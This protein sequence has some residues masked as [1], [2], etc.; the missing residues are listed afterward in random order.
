MVAELMVL[1][2]IGIVLV[3]LSGCIQPHR[4]CDILNRCKAQDEMMRQKIKRDK[5]LE[6]TDG[7]VI[8]PPKTQGDNC[9]DDH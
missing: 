1:T 2:A 6:V 8:P 9:N 5:E 3:A 4:S 7:K